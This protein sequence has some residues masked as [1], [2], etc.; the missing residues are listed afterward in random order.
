[1]AMHMTSAIQSCVYKGNTPSDV[2]LILFVTSWDL[3]ELIVLEDKELPN[4][5]LNKLF[6]LLP[7]H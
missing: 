2:N 6:L 4:P 5:L 7:L 3:V 1:M